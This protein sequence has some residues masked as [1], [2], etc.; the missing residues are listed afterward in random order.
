M[1]DVN[2]LRELDLFRAL[3]GLHL[4]HLAS[5]GRREEHAKGTVLFE[6]GDQGSAIHVVVEGSIRISK[7]VPGIGEEA[8][9]IL[10]PGS[11]FGEMEFIDRDL[12]RAAR[13]L[14]HERAALYTF[15]YGDLDDLLG[16]DR[17]LALAIQQAMLL[18]LTRRLRATNDKVT[19]MFAMAQ[20]G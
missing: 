8:L 7:M 2:V 9:A 1:I 16:T 19:A 4:A 6:E 11:Y 13:A 15:P 10:R 3:D 17:D 14:V 20:F 12:R 18:T 5:I